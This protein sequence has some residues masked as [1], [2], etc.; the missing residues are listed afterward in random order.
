MGAAG[1]GQGKRVFLDWEN[2][3]G[4]DDLPVMALP[5]ARPQR[6]DASA[7]RRADVKN[8]F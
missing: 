1:S 8:R 4:H 6:A 2:R 5:R 3:W 7:R